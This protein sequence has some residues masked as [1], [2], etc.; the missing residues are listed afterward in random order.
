[1]LAVI[2][3]NLSTY[4]IVLAEDNKKF[5]IHCTDNE[6]CLNGLCIGNPCLPQKN[7]EYE[8]NAFH[9]GEHSIDFGGSSNSIGSVMDNKNF[10]DIYQNTE[11]GNACTK[12]PVRTGVNPSGQKYGL[13]RNIENIFSGNS[14]T[15][16]LVKGSGVSLQM[17]LGGV[18]RICGIDISWYKGE[19][20]L[21]HFII[22]TSIDGTTF[23][24]ILRGTSGGTN[25]PSESY[26][27]IK[28]VQGRYIRLAASRDSDTSGVAKVGIYTINTKDTNS[29]VIQPHQHI[30]TIDNS[31]SGTKGFDHISPSQYID[32]IS[33][34]V[35]T[36]HVPTVSDKNVEVTSSAS[37]IQISL[38]GNDPDRT[39]AIKFSIIDLPS[40]GTLKQGSIANSIIYTP[41]SGFTGKDSFTYNAIDKH[42]AESLKGRVNILIS[43]KY[44]L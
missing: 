17:D 2:L 43:N 42:G 24:N 23:T 8:N 15:K 9:N 37:A 16:W 33:P 11:N 19:R 32:L 25:I 29:L 10:V 7:Y 21:Y 34:L 26:P 1:M 31:S 41:T 5:T 39:E 22:S 40:H 20:G 13:N 27:I 18:K 4:H 12:S 44:P 30:V 38:T 14:D 6:P 35:E 28:D 3:C 36:N